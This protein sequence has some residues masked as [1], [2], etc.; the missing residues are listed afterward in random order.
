MRKTLLLVAMALVIGLF[1]VGQAQAAEDIPN[2][3]GTWETLA[4]EQP[5]HSVKKGHKAHYERVL[6][7]V[8]GQE[9]RSFFGH[10]EKITDKK[11]VEKEKFSGVVYW[12]NKTIY[13]VDHHKGGVRATFESP[14]EFRGVYIEE[15]K[16][17]KIVLVIFKKIK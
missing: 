2:M 17:A 15:G 3:V 11:K 8:E 9:G 5:Q 4:G 14:T 6:M 7:V 13:T 12:D 1:G 16:E 10:V